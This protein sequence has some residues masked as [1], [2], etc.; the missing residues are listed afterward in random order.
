MTHKLR[1]KPKGYDHSK[2]KKDYSSIEKRDTEAAAVAIDTVTDPFTTL[3]D[4]AE[5]CGLSRDVI[6]SL[7]R[8]LQTKYQPVGENIKR[9]KTPQLLKIIEEKIHMA[10]EHMDEYTFA[11]AELRDLAVTFGILAEKRQLLMGEPTQILSVQERS[12]MN[13]LIQP[14][15]DE[16]RRRGMT[17]DVTP[18]NVADETGVDTRVLP[19]SGG[20]DN[21]VSRTARKFNKLKPAVDR[22][23]E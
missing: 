6:R 15:I 4:A 22:N 1:D 14:L 2:N 9:L 16:A 18:I 12:H 11:N 19:R 21:D 13:N 3:G 10:L 20:S 23:M 8:R 17:I 7:T 5:A